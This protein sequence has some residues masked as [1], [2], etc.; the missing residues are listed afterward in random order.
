M[1]DN[2]H[3]AFGS[4]D[5]GIRGE[6]NFELI[7]LLE[8]GWALQKGNKLKIW[9]S[10]GL[11][12]LVMLVVIYS[13]STILGIDPTSPTGD[14]DWKVSLFFQAAVGVTLM[15][16]TAGLYI[17][18][19]RIAC[20]VDTQA[21]EVL[22]YFEHAPKLLAWYFVHMFF[23]YAGFFALIVPGIYLSVAYQ[24]A[25]PIF[26]EKNLG[27][28]ESLEASRKALTSRWFSFAY[29]LLVLTSL[30]AL[31]LMTVIGLI[32]TLPWYFCTIGIL[33]RRIFG[34]EEVR[35]QL[36]EQAQA[37][38]SLNVPTLPDL[39]RYDRPK[40]EE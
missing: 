3:N 22:G 26:I 12:M 21:T 9:Q 11:I 15:P 27:I 32:W 19:I 23:T 39:S 33:Y 38:T 18:T 34:L 36:P 7:E 29:L 6:Y 20:G 8:E 10:M 17:M 1:S 16:L 40:D 13:L 30:A 35:P 4:L 28:W 31:S 14:E 2:T 24:L 37:G 5:S 25:L